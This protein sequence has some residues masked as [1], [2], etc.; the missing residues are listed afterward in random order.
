MAISFLGS[1]SPPSHW[2]ACLVSDA[3]AYSFSAIPRPVPALIR[4]QLF[5]RNH[6]TFLLSSSLLYPSSSSPPFSVLPATPAART[7]PASAA[8]AASAL[9]AA[10]FWHRHGCPRARFF[11]VTFPFSPL[12]THRLFSSPHRYPLP[13]PP[14]PSSAA[15]YAFCY[16]S[17]VS[18]EAFAASSL[19]VCC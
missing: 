6:A 19:L 7:R 18:I 5:S 1:D 16:S 2:L 3:N 10:I 15:T 17:T 11:M 13:W 14:S 4:K 8:A 12:T 9:A